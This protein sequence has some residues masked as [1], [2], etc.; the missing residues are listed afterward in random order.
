MK[1]EELDEI[2]GITRC[3]RCGQRL[4]N[5]VECP[6]CSLFPD[7]TRRSEKIPRWIYFTA[8]LLTS[9]ISIPFVITT[10][11]LNLMEKIIAVSGLIIWGIIYLLLRAIF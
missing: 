9:P 1:E 3:V 10:K 11:R 8:C 2:L 7:N 6:F 4:E 5:E